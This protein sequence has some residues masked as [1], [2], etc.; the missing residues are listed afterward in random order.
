MALR[1]ASE[2]Q[3]VCLFWAGDW[4]EALQTVCACLITKNE[5][6]HLPYCLASLSGQVDDI[7]VVDTGS[8][9]STI[10]IAQSF[11]CRVFLLRWR[12]DFSEARNYGVDQAT[13]DWILYIDADERLSCP[14]GRSLKEL[15]PGPTA[16]AAR[17]R[18]YPRLDMTAYAEYRLFRRDPRIRFAGSMHE[19]VL[20]DIRRACVEDGRT[21]ED[22]LEVELLH[23][24]YEGDQSAKHARNLPMLEKAI[25]TDPSRV[26]L[27]YHLGVTLRELGRYREAQASLAAGLESASVQSRSAQSKVEGSLCAHALGAM[28]LNDGDALAALEIVE[29]GNS[30]F[31]DNFALKLL[32]AEC[33]LALGREREAAELALQ[34]LECG[35]RELF[36]PH[37]AYPK[38][39]FSTACLSV[40]GSA[41]FRLKNY[42]RAALY[43]DRAAAAAPAQREYRIKADL[44]LTRAR[45]GPPAFRT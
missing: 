28:K 24:G 1:A 22:L 37:L 5:A 23:Y 19:T 4:G 30:L 41:Y 32:K 7:V 35:T 42:E 21:I 26:Y 39:L 2:S 14:N 10:S 12:D 31:A 29:R 11:N 33:L 15:L 36:D 16:I 6:A 34:I 44:A 38:H 3:V 25:A 9:D 18:F 17:V 43:F 20:P 40:L 27:R 13:A 45:G 8:V